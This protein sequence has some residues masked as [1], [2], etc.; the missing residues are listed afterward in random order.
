MRPE[1]ERVNFA[2]NEAKRALSWSSYLYHL[3]RALAYW[4]GK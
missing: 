1:I 4:I 3:D 2:I